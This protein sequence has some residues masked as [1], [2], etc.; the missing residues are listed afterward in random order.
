MA[1]LVDLG[2]RAGNST[3]L[4]SEG[5]TAHYGGPSPWPN[6][7][8]STEERFAA[9]TDHARCPVV[10][11]SWDRFHRSKGWSGLAYSSVVCPHGTRYEGRGLR[12]RTAANGTNPGNDRS[13]AVCYLAGDGDPLT[14]PARA[15]FHE[16][17]ARFGVRLRWTHQDWKSTSCPGEAVARWAAAGWPNPT[18]PTPPTPEE[19]DVITPED[20][21]A[22][23]LEV[24]NTLIGD[25]EVADDGYGEESIEAAHR[26][27]W[28][29]LIAEVQKDNDRTR[30]AIVE[31]R[32]ELRAATARK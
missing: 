1:P 8:R 17:A 6:A 4:R 5:I 29:S 11:R 13:H 15:A 10:V 2:L 22:I 24:V 19:F 20:R 16:E 9:T 7:D 31:L 27:R 3:N 18:R 25:P 32:K 14:D 12:H 30:A 21:K 28:W 26:G 23:A